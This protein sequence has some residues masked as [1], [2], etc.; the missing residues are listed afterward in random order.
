MIF[1]TD[2]SLKALIL[3][4]PKGPDCKKEKKNLIV[5]RER[6]SSENLEKFPMDKWDHLCFCQRM[7]HASAERSLQLKWIFLQLLLLL[8]LQTCSLDQPKTITESFSNYLHRKNTFN[9]NFYENITQKNEAQSYFMHTLLF[10]VEW[11]W[12]RSHVVNQ[13]QKQNTVFL[14]IISYEKIYMSWD[15]YLYVCIYIYRCGVHMMKQSCPE[16]W[17]RV[18]S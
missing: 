6:K 13:I 18:R 8:L 7:Q 2:S 1:W 17:T 9:R 5:E 16:N 10:L 11:G 15:V 14:V 4:S 3:F 12:W